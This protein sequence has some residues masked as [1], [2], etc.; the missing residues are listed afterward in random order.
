MRTESRCGPMIVAVAA[1]VPVMA[2][3]QGPRQTLVVTGHAGSLPV[4]L[5]DGRNYV[6]IEALARLANVSLTFD[7]NQYTLT[8][9]VTGGNARSVAGQSPTPSTGLSGEFLRAAIE[10]MSTVREWH[11]AL[12][13]AIENQFPLAKG[14]L[15]SYQAQ[16]RTNLR[17]A[18]T[19]ATSDADKSAMQ[20][21]TN[22]FEKMA[23][24]NDKYVRDRA[25]MNYVAPDALKNDP[26][27]QS[28]IACGKSL[29]AMAASGQFTDDGSCH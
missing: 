15:A 18:Q 29:G 17:L 14:G 7:G 26:L 8:L 23:Q 3:S 2:S 12:A 4:A 6:D 11:S 16:A 25:D 24:L 28:L 20:L 1:V 27:D 21:M 5:I 10:A 13:S 9:P 19:A 22:G